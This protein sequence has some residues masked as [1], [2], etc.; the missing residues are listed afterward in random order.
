MGLGGK[1]WVLGRAMGLQQCI[2]Q[3]CGG[4]CV[5][6]SGSIAS[7]VLLQ[8]RTID[9]AGTQPL[10]S[11]RHPDLMLQPD[12]SINIT[13]PECYGFGSTHYPR[14]LSC[15]VALTRALKRDEEIGQVRF[16]AVCVCVAGGR[17][18]VSR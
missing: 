8:A 17:Q 12:G 2:W 7:S 3:R 11:K 5:T 1:G 10:W 18:G 9:G 13:T 4:R 14:D 6:R 16:C 15:L